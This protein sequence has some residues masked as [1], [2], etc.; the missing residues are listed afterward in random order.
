MIHSFSDWSRWLFCYS[1]SRT[2]LGTREY[3][4]TWITNKPRVNLTQPSEWLCVWNDHYI[5]RVMSEQDRYVIIVVCELWTSKIVAVKGGFPCANDGVEWMPKCTDEAP[6]NC[7]ILLQYTLGN[8][9]HWMYPVIPVIQPFWSNSFFTK[10]QRENAM[11]VLF[12]RKQ[13]SVVY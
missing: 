2:N 8:K 3:A 6:A 9:D 11:Q 7:P 10:L 5:I 1:W 12:A 4:E 13:E